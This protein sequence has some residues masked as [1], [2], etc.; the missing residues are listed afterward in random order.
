MSIWETPCKRRFVWETPYKLRGRHASTTKEQTRSTRFATA[1]SAPSAPS[2]RPPNMPRKFAGED[3]R[4][5]KAKAQKA[6]AAADKSARARAAKAAADDASWSRG[7][8][9]N[10]AKRA[11]KQAAE[12]AKKAAKRAAQQEAEA[13]DAASL[14]KMRKP[15]GKARK[16]DKGKKGKGKKMTAFERQ[17]LAEAKAA[18]KKQAAKK[19]AAQAAG[20][21]VEVDLLQPNQNKARGAGELLEASTLEGAMSVLDLATKSGGGGAAAAGAVDRHPERRAKAAFAAFK[22]RMTTEIRAEQPGLKKSQIDERIWKL[23]Q[24]SEENPRY[25][26]GMQ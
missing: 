22:E 5:L 24:K 13:S 23:W 17:M 12:A 20:A 1:P 9:A 26:A 2:A 8:N 21:V 16:A 7:A 18:R 4:G 25:V 6:A 15:R 10:A 19:K 11:D 3:T 14:A